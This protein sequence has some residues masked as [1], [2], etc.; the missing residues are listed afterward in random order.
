MSRSD[1]HIHIP[2]F[3]STVHKAPQKGVPKDE[4]DEA[5]ETAP[6]NDAMDVPRRKPSKHG[7]EKHNTLKEKQS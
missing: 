1:A 6:E 7:S 5:S 2:D 4:L 3:R